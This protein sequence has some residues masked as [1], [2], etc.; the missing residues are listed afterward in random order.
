M[1]NAEWGAIP[2]QLAE[3]VSLTLK[4]K[5]NVQTGFKPNEWNKNIKAMTPLP[6][7]T[8][9]GSVVTF[10][11]GAD[12]VPLKSCAVTIAP[13]LDGVSSVDVVSAGKNVF[14]IT[15]Y[16]ITKKRY[17]RASDG[18]FAISTIDLRGATEYY[19]PC[20][21]MRGKTWV[22]NKPNQSSNTM[23]LAFYDENKA[24][25]SSVLTYPSGTNGVFTVPNDA[26]YFRFTVDLDSADDTEI[27]IE[28]GTTVTAYTSYVTPTTHTAQLGRT[29]YGGTIDV[30]NGTGTESYDVIRLDSLPFIKNNNQNN[31]NG[32]YFSLD[33]VVVP[34]IGWG[35]GYGGRDTAMS[36]VL[37]KGSISATG[38]TE[39]NNTFWWNNAS[40]GWRVIWGEPNGGSSL[41]DFMAFL[42]ANNVVVGGTLSTPETF[43]FT[44][45]PID[46]L[47]G[48]N[49]MW[50]DGDLSVIYRY[51]AGDP[52]FET[53]L[54][55]NPLLELTGVSGTD[56]TRTLWTYTATDHCK[57]KFHSNTQVRTNTGS[58]DGYFTVK[59]N[60]TVILTTYANTSTTTQFPIPDIELES[61]DTVTIISGFDNYHT[62]CWFDVYSTIT[63]LHVDN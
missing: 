36:N 62:S 24:F 32:T 18:Y 19:I 38:S 48:D 27:Q 58:N 3:D 52:S 26:H 37:D 44:P 46:S 34:F 55:S 21:S 49:T 22:I 17:I 28:A 20:V 43:T 1:S 14:D 60:D 40:T 54:S 63:I 57:I 50:G 16:P 13:T 45:V 33:G 35:Y 10:S 47:Y 39:P 42:T 41:A 25:L 30:V 9:S 4:R 11:D 6:E 12:D 23:G 8:V 59:K 61:G 5:F 29:I 15:T 7:K 31:P 53:V 51:V 56:V 2:R